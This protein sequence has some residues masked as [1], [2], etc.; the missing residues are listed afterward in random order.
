[1]DYYVITDVLGFGNI[2]AILIIFILICLGLSALSKLHHARSFQYR[3]Y[4]SNLFIV[5]KLRKYAK[6]D[7]LD[8]EVEALEF[9][10]F[11][12]MNKPKQRLEIDDEIE[13]LISKRIAKETV[14]KDETK[15]PSKKISK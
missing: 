12:K 9:K 5:S 10:K 7:S 6:E 2:F 15:E 8:L 3:K 14:D 1:M 11:D 4:M 13:Q